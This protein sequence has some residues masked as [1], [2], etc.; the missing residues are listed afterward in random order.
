[1]AAVKEWEGL[2]LKQAAMKLGAHCQI[3]PLRE[4]GLPVPSVAPKRIRLA[5]VG[6]NPHRLDEK[7]HQPFTGLPGRI[8]DAELAKNGI[9]R[10]EAYLGNTS[11]CRGDSD[12]EN[13]R[14][15]ECCAPRLLRE[16]QI[17]DANI[18]I[19]TMGKAPLRAVLGQRNLLA[20][21]GF[22]WTA[23][24]IPA[25]HVKSTLRQ[26]WKR[27]PG[28]KRDSAVLRGETL[29]AR[30]PLAGRVVLPSLHPGFFLR[31]DTW[32]PVFQ[33]D[34]RRCGNL[35]NG[36][37]AT[38]LEDVAPYTVGGPE[39]LHGL[40]GTVSLDVE[41]DGIDPMVCKMLC[42]GI[43]DATKTVVIWPWHKR[44]AKPVQAFLRSRS[45]VICHNG[46]YDIP[47][48]RNH[49]VT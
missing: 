2:A 33:I 39:L 40:Q 14:A 26:A 18:P 10:S 22:I 28:P 49:G 19:L 17:Q 4:K 20:A 48:M 47:V 21:R 5:I 12:K 6:D 46:I 44:Y 43:S 7:L 35:L 11:L 37:L 8:L 36:S 38:P 42:V 29:A 13:E 1:M 31:A 24:E 23:K 45:E 30:G 9:R 15:G 32:N 3:C 27:K 34:I 41:T 16:L 25:A